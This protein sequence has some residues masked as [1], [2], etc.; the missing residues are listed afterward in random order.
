M[1]SYIKKILSQRIDD[2]IIAHSDVVLLC[3]GPSLNDVNLD[4]ITMPVVGMNKIYMHK[5]AW[6]KV[7]VLFVVNKLVIRQ[8]LRDYLGGTFRLN[9]RQIILPSHR[10]FSR[11]IFKN[12]LGVPTKN[13]HEF[14]KKDFFSIGSTVTNVAL[15]FLYLSRVRSVYVI[16]MDHSFTQSGHAN[17]EQVLKDDDI[18]HFDPNYFKNHKWHL[19]DLEGSEVGYYRAKAKFE[20]IGGKII[21]VGSSKFNGWERISLE[22]FYQIQNENA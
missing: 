17:E 18:N 22:C 13:D 14:L 3:N 12:S 16:G 2:S 6:K 15:Q 10:L 8:V 19:A 4:L 21:N 5:K 1:L 20:D 9:S 11:V 7:D